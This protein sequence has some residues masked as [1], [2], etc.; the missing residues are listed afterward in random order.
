MA[1]VVE[2]EKQKSP[3]TTV[4]VV[5][6]VLIIVAFGSYYL[7]FSPAP[8]IQNIV[9]PADLQSIDQTSKIDIS[10]VQSLASSTAY[11]NLKV[12]V[13]PQ[14]VNGYGRSDP[15]QPY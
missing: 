7:F 1:I 9:V 2:G 11:T 6:I 14:Q 15:F 12:L 4:V 5:I 10:V 8:A 3:I 13:P